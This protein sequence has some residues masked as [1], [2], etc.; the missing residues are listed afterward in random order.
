MPK[1]AETESAPRRKTLHAPTMSAA[2]RQEAIARA[3]WLRAH[4]RTLGEIAHA[5]S[6]LPEIVEGW[7]RDVPS[8]K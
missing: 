6:V 8:A 4:G 5:L 1:P 7:L 2:Y 3:R